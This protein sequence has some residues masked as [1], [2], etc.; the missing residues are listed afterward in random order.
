MLKIGHRG[1]RGYE[2]ENTLIG[3]QKAIDLHVDRIELDVHLSSDGE[4]MV[5][6]DE[7]IDRTT[8]GK[9]AV[10][11]FSLP[12]LKRFQIEKSQCIPTLTEV[13][14]LIDQRCDV[15]IELKSYDTAD[16]V[17]DLIEKFIAEKNWNY[18]QFVVSSFDWTA[19][20]QVALLNWEIRIGV[21]TETDLDLAVAF[22]KFIQAKSIHPYHHLLTAENTAQLQ[23]KGF[24]VFPWTVN[25]PEDIK[26]IK[27][28]NVNGII[29]DFPDRI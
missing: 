15:N 17:V 29:S 26:K 28:F 25:E 5:I 2:P 13:L 7:T 3:F 20:Q 23:E 12:E 4:I 27:S 18:S 6:H 1:A 9:G 8:N 21:L 19:L 22:A 16:K 24:E 14:N 11:Q 10:N